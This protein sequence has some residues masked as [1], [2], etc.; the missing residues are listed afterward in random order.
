MSS[1]SFQASKAANLLEILIG[2]CL[3][4]SISLSFL[5]WNLS[6]SNLTCYLFTSC[7]YFPYVR[8][9]HIVIGITIS[10]PE[11]TYIEYT[12]MSPPYVITIF[13]FLPDIMKVRKK[14]CCMQELENRF[15]ELRWIWY[16]GYWEDLLTSF[17]TSHTS[18]NSDKS[19]G[20][21]ALRPTCASLHICINIKIVPKK[22]RTETWNTFHVRCSFSRVFRSPR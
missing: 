2:F 3:L 4:T 21:S 20:N 11:R 1:P 12:R 19:N 7:K 13:K 14:S 9:H 10:N 5:R 18:L 16:W 6:T 17:H 15:T 8:N 22:R